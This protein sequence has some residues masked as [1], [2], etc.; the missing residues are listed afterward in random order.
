MVLN[1]EYHFKYMHTCLISKAVVLAFLI[2]FVLINLFVMQF[3]QTYQDSQS[4]NQ[5]ELTVISSGV[6]IRTRGVTLLFGRG[7][8]CLSA[9]FQYC[10]LYIFTI[11]FDL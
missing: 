7:E 2:A 3:K 6:R 11:C 8:M 9:V 10:S 1:H 5:A 4:T